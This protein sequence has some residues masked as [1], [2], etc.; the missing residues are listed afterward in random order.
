[1]FIP[2]PGSEF[3]HPRYRVKKIPDPG[4]G[5]RFFTH[6]DPGVKKAPDPRSGSAKL[7]VA[8]QVISRITARVLECAAGPNTRKAFGEDSI[9]KVDDIP[10]IISLKPD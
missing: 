5:S 2:D 1:M 6:P 4:S 8:V 10:Q 9:V 7:I 3:F